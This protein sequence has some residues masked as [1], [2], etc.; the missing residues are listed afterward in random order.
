MDNEQQKTWRRNSAVFD[1]RADEY[2]SW[3]DDS[4]LF[5]IELA[6]I[7]QLQT[8]LLGPKLELGVGPGRFA[9]ELGTD[10]GLDPAFA[11]LQISRGRDIGVMQGVGESIPL[12]ES[13]VATVYLLFTLCFVASPQEVLAECY[14]VLQP[15]GHLVLG[16]VP[17]SGA[18]G[19]ALNIKKEKNHPFYKYASFYMA[20]KVEEFLQDAGFA[21]VEQRSSL[22]QEPVSLVEL[23]H[24]RLGLSEQAGFCLLVGQK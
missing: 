4:L 16:V 20:N 18:W 2:D 13:S 11:P 9:Q 6:A 24:S 14:R 22:F 7:K 15:D 19:Q 17:A 3:Y 5:D 10:F 1:E 12:N 8:S 23:E 21:I